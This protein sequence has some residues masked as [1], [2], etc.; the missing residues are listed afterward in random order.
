LFVG[1][2]RISS[3]SDHPALAAS[4]YN[5]G[6]VR[7][8]A[9]LSSWLR[10]QVKRGLIDLDNPEEAAVILIGMVASV[11]A[12]SRVQWRLGCGN[13]Q[14]CFCMAAKQSRGRK[15]VV[16]IVSGCGMNG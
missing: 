8:T 9:A 13:A 10:L 4:F 14:N 12:S 6:I 1:F 15:A 11:P 2:P 16:R 3:R 7:T 5:N